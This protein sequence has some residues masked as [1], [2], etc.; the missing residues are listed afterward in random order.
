MATNIVP[1]RDARQLEQD[2]FAYQGDGSDKNLVVRR[3]EDE[4]AASILTQILSALGGGPGGSSDNH[5]QAV[6]ALIYGTLPQ[7]N[8]NGITRSTVGTDFEYIFSYNG[9][10]Q[11]KVIVT[12][13]VGD[14]TITIEEFVNKLLL[15]DDFLFQLED[16]SNILLEG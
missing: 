8:W 12:D 10:N 2:N 4:I 15:E 16:D 5:F 1:D 9:N 11:F 14:Y 7:I 6:L 3:V 13:P